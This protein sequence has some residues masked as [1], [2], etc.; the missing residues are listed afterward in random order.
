LIFFIIC[1]LGIF[2]WR[3]LN[4]HSKWF[5]FN[6]L[7]SICWAD[8]G[9]L[10]GEFASIGVDLLGSKLPTWILSVN[11]KLILTW[12]SAHKKLVLSAI[13]LVSFIP[14]DL[15]VF[16]ITYILP[17]EGDMACSCSFGVNISYC[18]WFW[19][20]CRFFGFL[21]RGLYCCATF[22]HT[23]D[24]VLGDETQLLSFVDCLNGHSVVFASHLAW[25]L[26]LK[27]SL[28]IS[29]VERIRWS[30]VVFLRYTK[31]VL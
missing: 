1:L 26:K 15:V 6:A 2:L 16:G 8:I 17:D 22:R 28:V 20:R 7:S 13:F 10:E 5:R 27:F 14:V 30:Q 18:R 29:S 24:S 23:E 11:S 3:R 25:C 9:H 19:L 4:C 31:T 21:F 12:S